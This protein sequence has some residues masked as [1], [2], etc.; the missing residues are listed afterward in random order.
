MFK[1]AFNKLVSFAWQRQVIRYPEGVSIGERST[2]SGTFTVRKAGGRIHV[3]AD[4]LIEGSLGTET[5]VSRLLIG[6]NVY[7]GRSVLVSVSSLIVEDDVL[8]SSD[9]LIQDSDNHNIRYSVRKNDCQDWK[10]G[11]HHDWGVTPTAP[12]RICRGAWI[13]AKSIVLKGV[14]VGEGA[15]VGAGSVVTRNV[16]PYTVV[17]GNPARLIRVIDDSNGLASCQGQDEC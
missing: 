6:N 10:N 3:G 11:Q 7:I 16:D 9:C 8:I 1:S 5:E 14:T 13:G 15:V 4:C 17:A 12:V 2:F